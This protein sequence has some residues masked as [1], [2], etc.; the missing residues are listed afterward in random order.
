MREVKRI[1]VPIDFSPDAEHALDLAL[2]LLKH[3]D[4][5]LV[6][7]HVVEE[8]SYAAD[9]ALT[10]PPE[11]VVKQVARRAEVALE[12]LAKRVV[13]G[14]VRWAA[15]VAIGRPAGEIARI[16]EEEKADM[17]VMG[18]LGLTGLTHMLVGSVTEKVVRTAPCPVLTVRRGIT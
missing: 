11:P 16:A 7:L 2:G 1:L 17:I 9:L 13:P 15:R 14:G 5:M 12:S 18:T 8:M 3:D 4:S 6:L 10:S